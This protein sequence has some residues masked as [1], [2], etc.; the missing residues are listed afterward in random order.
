[1]PLVPCEC[2]GPSR[3]LRAEYDETV[4]MQY[5]K[6]ARWKLA[7]VLRTAMIICWKQPSL[8]DRNDKCLKADEPEGA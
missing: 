5:N 6:L 3:E 1:M 8:F 7:V 4:V 2:H